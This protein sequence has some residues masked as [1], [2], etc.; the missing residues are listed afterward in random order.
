MPVVVGDR[1]LGVLNIESETAIA[2]DDI[3]DIEAVA[4]QLGIAIENASRYEDE[5]RR[6]ERLRLLARVGQRIAAR[7]DPE[8]VFATTVAELHGRLGYDHVALFLLD[9]T[10]P[11]WLVQRAR[12]SRWPRGE[13]AG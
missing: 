10:D 11:T 1:L 2:A 9:P 6:A 13:A 12:A 5:Q 7:L 4:D 3:A 8:E